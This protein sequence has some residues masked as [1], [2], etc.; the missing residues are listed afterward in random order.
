MALGSQPS[1]ECASVAIGHRATVVATI[2]IAKPGV[3]D[4]ATP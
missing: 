2:D 3:V 1:L 4:I